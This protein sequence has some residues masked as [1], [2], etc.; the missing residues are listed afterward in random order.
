MFVTAFMAAMAWQRR[1]PLR[2]LTVVRAVLLPRGGHTATGHV[3]AFLWCIRH[4]ALL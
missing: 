1:H 4:R 2:V 3:G